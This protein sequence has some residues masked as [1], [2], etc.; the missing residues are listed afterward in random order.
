M[1]SPGQMLTPESRSPRS[2]FRLD[3][4]RHLAADPDFVPTV[5]LPAPAIAI[6]LMMPV[7]ARWLPAASGR[8]AAAAH[9]ARRFRRWRAARAHAGA[10]PCRPRAAAGALRALSELDAG[11]SRMRCGRGARADGGARCRDRGERRS[12]QNEQGHGPFHERAHHDLLP[13]DFRADCA[14]RAGLR[15]APT[16]A[17]ARSN[18]TPDR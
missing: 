4:F 10:R 2:W 6:M 12:R 18:F 1:F 13:A 14:R 8:T 5:P 11:S 16:T 17:V 7:L 9:A 15:K 3:P